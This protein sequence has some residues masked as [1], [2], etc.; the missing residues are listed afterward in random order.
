V[1]IPQS[2][3]SKVDGVFLRDVG[4]AKILLTATNRWPSSA[5]LSVEFS[6]AGHLVSILCP[7]RDH[8]SR[9]VQGIAATFPYRSLTPLAAVANAI[10]A[11]EPD[12]VIPCDDLAVRHLHQLYASKRSRNASRVDIQ[13]L[14]VRSI[15]PPSS[16][17]TVD[18]RH[19]LLELSRNEGVLTPE[20]SVIA[21]LGDFEKWKAGHPLPWALKAEGTTGGVGVR[22]A[23]T[24][25]EARRYYCDLS[26]P[27]GFLRSV[28]HL[29]VDRDLILEGHWPNSW[30]RTRPTIIVQS[31]VRGGAANCAVACWQGEILAG[32]CCEVISTETAVGPATVVRLVDNGDMMIAARRIARRLG[33]SGFFGLDFVLEERSGAVYLIEMNPR[34]TPPTHLRLGAGRD[35]VGAL[36]AQLTGVPLSEPVSVTQNSLIAYFPEA[37]LR[38]SEFLLSSYHDV[39]DS[40]PELI[41]ALCRPKLRRGV[42]SDVRRLLRLKPAST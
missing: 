5:R 20:T 25:E 1:N 37:L 10:E 40:E 3:R 31:F 6:R 11:T 42:L 17:E 30:R 28:K 21:G 15:G 33:L 24:L 9:K 35:M 18:S 16:Y 32:V 41:E 19:L 12:I 27:M 13:A 7:A 36:S 4:T 2:A 39:P 34:C 29:A 14:I 23:C 8:P 26:R 22:I 38:K